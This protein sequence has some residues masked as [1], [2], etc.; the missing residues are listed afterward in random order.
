MGWTEFTDRP[1]LS[2]AEMIRRELSQDPTPENP[3]AWGFEYIT[4]RGST[5]YAI[6]W[7]DAPD[8]PRKYFGLVC[9]TRRFKSNW[10]GRAFSYKDMTE[11]VGPYAYDAPAKMLDMLDRL[12]PNPTG[13]AAEWRKKCRERI[14]AQKTRTVWKAGDRVNNGRAVYVLIEPAGPR[15]GW[16]VYDE[17]TGAR[18]RMPAAQLARAEKLEPKEQ[19]FRPS[20]QVDAA[21]FIRE[22]FQFIHVGDAA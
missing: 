7:S 19:P 3:R 8:R 18:Y 17:A 6:G 9:L 11:D 4:E 16:R 5:V 12:A 21:E 15:K 20:K 13:Y 14:D 2:R 1:D 22:H 10:C